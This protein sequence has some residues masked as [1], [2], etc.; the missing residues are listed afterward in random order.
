MDKRISIKNVP[1]EMYMEQL[2]IEVG[3]SFQILN[4]EDVIGHIHLSEL[5]DGNVYI[6]WVEFFP[7]HRGKHY[8]RKV[9]LNVMNHFQ[10]DIL[11]F[12]TSET[13]LEMYTYM[14]A[15]KSEYDS[16]TEM[17]KMYIDRASVADNMYLGIVLDHVNYEIKD[18]V[19]W[20]NCNEKYDKKFDCTQVINVLTAY[21]KSNNA[22]M[23]DLQNLRVS[24]TGL[25][26]LG[27]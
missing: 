4:N 27:T 9:L 12:R 7:E 5:I 24:R 17:T 26:T 16:F 14:G 1:V 22:N 15:V 20:I 13:L 21:E 11:Y 25:L 3:Y 23:I 10:K 8:F 19:L 18:G 2:G 6:E